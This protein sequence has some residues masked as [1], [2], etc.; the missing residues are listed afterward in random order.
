[1]S[2]GDAATGPALEAKI[3]DLYRDFFNKAER[4]RRWNLESDIPWDQCN[5]NLD[6]AIADVV[7]TFCSVELFLPDYVGKILPLIRGARGRAWFAA[8]W[9][10][11]ESKHSLALGDWLVRSGFRTEHDMEKIQR[12]AVEHEW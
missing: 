5:R 6:P 3:Y 10:Y 4:R 8:N 7:E 2:E 1:M 11:E 9:V 12:Y